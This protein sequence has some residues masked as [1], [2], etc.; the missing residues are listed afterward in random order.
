LQA[1]YRALGVTLEFVRVP[2]ARALLESNAGRID[3][4]LARVA[5]IESTYPNLRRIEP[6]LFFNENA[7]FVLK[8]Q[9]IAPPDLKA[10]ARLPA[11]GV[12]NGY[13]ITE[14]L[15]VGWSNVVRI[16]SYVSALKMLVAGR[17]SAF[18]G[19][20]EDVQIA[21]TQLGLD[22]SSFDEQVLLSV[23]L[24]HYLNSKHEALIP[25]ISAELRRLQGKQGSVLPALKLVAH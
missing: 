22:A 23:P 10:L 25:A 13:K 6:V 16:N 1:A 15:T 12:L 11:V 7:V 19:R 4:E 9:R 21:I 18:F 20:K 2:A 24:Y 8:N 17:I 14:E 5:G 3:G